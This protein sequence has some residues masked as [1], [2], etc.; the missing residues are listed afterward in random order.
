MHDVLTFHVSLLKSWNAEKHGV[1]PIPPTLTLAE[2]QEFE[3]HKIVDHREK[4][5]HHV[6]KGRPKF[7]R[8]YLVSWRLFSEARITVI[9]HGNQKRICRMRARK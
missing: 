8:E 2:Q 1:I 3:V 7:R 6:G 5:V 4:H 9:I